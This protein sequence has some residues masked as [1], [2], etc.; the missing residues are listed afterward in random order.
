MSRLAMGISSFD[1]AIQGVRIVDGNARKD[2]RG[3]LTTVFVRAGA[4]DLG[5]MKQWNCIRSDANV[6]RGVHAHLDY[7]ELYVPILGRMFLLLKDARI[8][9]SSF[10]EEMSFYL[11]EL[12]ASAIWVPA[13]VAHGVYFAT[14]GI[15]TYGLSNVYTGTLEF[16]FS[17]NSSE[18]RSA[19]PASDPILSDRDSKARSFS[20]MV[21]DMAE[22]L[23]AHID[24]RGR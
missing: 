6:L 11:D 1:M 21:D 14:P 15:L 18:I 7:G 13:G 3:S 20:E 23:S 16:N 4:D 10:G 5:E 19:W 8:N 2:H 9:S 17:W 22:A 24:G 12:E